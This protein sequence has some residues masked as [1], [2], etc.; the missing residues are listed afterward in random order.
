[1]NVTEKAQDLIQGRPR[2]V[3]CFD[4]YISNRNSAE[5]MVECTH[6]LDS[7]DKPRT[8]VMARCILV[9]EP[10]PRGTHEF[11][12]LT[13]TM[14]ANY[15]LSYLP[16]KGTKQLAHRLLGW[17]ITKLMEEGIV[18]PEDVMFL[19]RGHDQYGKSL[20]RYYESIGFTPI[21]YS[22][23]EIHPLQGRVPETGHRFRLHG[24][25]FMSTTLAN[26]LR[27][28]DDLPMF[29]LDFTERVTRK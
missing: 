28:W 11:R 19:T 10:T 29:E 1:M 4:L 22:K 21:P 7:A 15:R 14:I 5:S 6:Y 18:A 24:G 23:T 26:Y 12:C 9:F 13:L 3:Y 25:E 27:H 16:E 17:T 2:P 8:T 20:E